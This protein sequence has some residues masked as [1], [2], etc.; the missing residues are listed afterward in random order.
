MATDAKKISTDKDHETKGLGVSLIHLDYRD[1][2]PTNCSVREKKNDKSCVEKYEIEFY[3][4]MQLIFTWM[5]CKN[6]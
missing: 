3:L 4:I 5:Y 1:F 2:Q 6:F